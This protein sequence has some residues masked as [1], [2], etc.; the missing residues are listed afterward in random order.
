MHRARGNDLRSTS[1]RRWRSRRRKKRVSRLICQRL[2]LRR[3]LSGPARRLLLPFSRRQVAKCESLVTLY[4]RSCQPD[5]HVDGTCLRSVRPM[6]SNRWSHLSVYGAQ[7]GYRPL[8]R[9]SVA[10]RRGYGEITSRGPHSW[11]ARHPAHAQRV[12]RGD[13][14][15]HAPSEY[16]TRANGT[17]RYPDADSVWFGSGNGGKNNSY[18]Q[19]ARWVGWRWSHG[20]RPAGQLEG[21]RWR[22]LA[23]V[24][25]RG[26]DSDAVILLP[27][28]IDSLFCHELCAVFTCNHLLRFLL[29]TF[30]LFTE[31]N[32]RRN[33]HASVTKN[34]DPTT[35]RSDF[36]MSSN[37]SS[38]D[39]QSG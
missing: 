11:I 27:E 28:S 13:D 36:H 5:T 10:I 22:R 2:R 3:R 17:R 39:L 25:W 33:W 20:R 14:R 26:H 21:R 34:I 19:R 4:Q 16:H 8:R 30:S 7:I 9:R 18:I 24:E 35:M 15:G 6:D 29:R 1:G 31:L 32:V 38:T 12:A 23:E 37:D